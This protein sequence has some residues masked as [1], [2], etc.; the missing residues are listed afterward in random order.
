MRL[1]HRPWLGGSASNWQNRL[2]D[3]RRSLTV[4]LP[5]GRLDARQL[6]LQVGACLRIALAAP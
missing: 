3:G 6:A 4:E 1:L 5:A 2:P